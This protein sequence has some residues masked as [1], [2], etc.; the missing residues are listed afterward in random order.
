[1]HI[2]IILT[3][4][5][6][7]VLPF[8]Y[9]ASLGVASLD[10]DPA[11]SEAASSVAEDTCDSKSLAT[12]SGAA[13]AIKGF[14]AQVENDD[15]DTDNPA[16]VADTA[17]NG[18][19]SGGFEPSGMTTTARLAAKSNCMVDV[20]SEEDCLDVFWKACAKG[21]KYGKGVAKKGCLEFRID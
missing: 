19:T 8:A 15:S 2:P 6:F 7:T 18:Y 20:G 4:A 12:G 5:V 13:A 16:S 9:G 21:D 17:I 14:C 10:D 3:M 11:S 1:M